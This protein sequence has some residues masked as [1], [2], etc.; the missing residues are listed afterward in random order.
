[1]S[2]TNSPYNPLFLIDYHNKETFHSKLIKLFL[3][4]NNSEGGDDFE[5]QNIKNFI[6]LLNSKRPSV[7]TNRVSD[8]LL[9]A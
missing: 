9:Q 7:D 2:D 1:M 3:D 5:Y 6:D 8:Y 4:V